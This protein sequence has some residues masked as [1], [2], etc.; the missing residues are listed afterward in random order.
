MQGTNSCE[1][2][3]IPEKRKTT[4]GRKRWKKG[5]G[6]IFRESLCDLGHP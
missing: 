5:R 6:K 2:T 1:H 4:R 3:H